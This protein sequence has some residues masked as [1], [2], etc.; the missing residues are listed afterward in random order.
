MAHLA[1]ERSPLARLRDR[2]TR[3]PYVRALRACWK[4][5]PGSTALLMVMAA[6]SGAVPLGLYFA[7]AVFA[8][9]IAAPAT[10]LWPPEVG[11]AAIGFFFLVLQLREPIVRLV[12]WRL[13]RR[14]DSSLQQTVMRAS[15]TPR[16]IAHMHTEAF[17]RAAT[18]VRDWDTSAHPP[19]S[20]VWAIVNMTQNL[21]VAVG[22]G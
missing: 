9:G 8:G 13:A 2:I 20:A 3:V 17:N 22:S 16:T 15:V 18:A 4:A 11:I 12:L 1:R 10:A 5:A 19:S 21:I 6:L 7:F 14:L